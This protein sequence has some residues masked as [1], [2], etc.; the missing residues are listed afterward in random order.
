MKFLLNGCSF[1]AAG[2]EF[3]H[4][5]TA[6]GCDEFV[7]LAKSGSSNRRIIRTTVDHAETNSVDFVAI[8]LTFWDRQEGAFL[9]TQYNKD[10]WVSFSAHGTQGLFAPDDAEFIFGASRE[11][12][13][14]HV[15]DK[16]RYD[17]NLQY[18][19]QLLIDVIMLHGYL[20][21]RGIRHVIFN[22]CELEYP[23][24]FDTVNNR[25]RDSISNIKNIVPL[26]KFVM[27][28]FLHSLGSKR[29]QNEKSLEPNC[30]H[31]TSKEYRHVSDY[32]LNY[33]N[34]NDL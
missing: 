33:V 12:I 5:S 13:Q 11:M 19:D 27:N 10:N 16:Y 4:L 17:I 26:D 15:Q 6:L 20:S 1:L 28:I 22:T 14:R 24:Y 8:G 25:Y 7:N 3:K 29:S 32:L 34:N 18:I 9:N 30:V 31:Y 21:N 2:E 23:G